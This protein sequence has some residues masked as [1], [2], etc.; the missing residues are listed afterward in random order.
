MLPAMGRSAT[1]PG[2]FHASGFS[3]HGFQ[4]GPGAGDATAELS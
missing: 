1:T 3:G 2:L 4:L